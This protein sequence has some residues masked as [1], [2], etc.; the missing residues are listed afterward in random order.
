[1]ATTNEPL[2]FVGP[3]AT[4]L[5]GWVAEQ[6]A[7]G[8]HYIRQIHDLSRFD[9]WSAAIEHRG[10]ALPQSL[11]EQWTTK[12]PHGKEA[13]RQRRVILLGGLAQ[14]M[15]RQ[16]I[17]AWLPPPQAATPH[18][19]PH[20]FTRSELAALF[21]AIDACPPD[22][23]SPYRHRVFPV[24]FRVLY[25][26]GVRISEALALTRRDFDGTAGTIHIRH[27]KGDKE[28]RLPLHPVLVGMLRD[29]IAELAGP[30]Q[31]GP[32]FPNPRGQAYATR[33]L[34]VVFRRFL[35]A[36]GISHGGRGAGPRLHDIRH[37]GIL[38]VMGS[39]SG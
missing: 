3:F 22:A 1:M 13:T 8:Y 24:L 14:Y 7:L 10:S 28:R 39:V 38:S 16:G 15:Q 37:Y 26:T 4:V 30:D 27:G 33:T 36:A 21:A 11:V 35:W 18:Y 31:D 17:S 23:R 12:R 34:Y 9:Q 5:T 29:Y 25:G 6:R 19:L 2:H 20:I 32:L